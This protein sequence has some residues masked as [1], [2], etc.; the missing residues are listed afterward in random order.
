MRRAKPLLGTLVEVETDSGNSEQDNLAVNAAFAEIIRLE[1]LLTRF[2]PESDVARFNSLALDTELL[3]SPEVAVLFKLSQFLYKLTGGLFNPSV[4][5]ET[6]QAADFSKISLKGFRIKKSVP[7]EVDFAG[8]GKGYIV[9]LAVK[10]L[11]AMAPHSGLINAGGDIKV[12]GEKTYPVYIRSSNDA[13]K[14]FFSAELNNGAL[15]TSSGYFRG[16]TKAGKNF[17]P[18]FDPH[19]GTAVDAGLSVSV[20]ATS[21]WCAD[22]LTK[23]TA[24]LKDRSRDYISLLK[25]RAFL[26][27]G[28]FFREL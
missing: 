17:Q 22:A 25:A 24:L 7:L 28:D 11:R 4:N 3:L 26:Q 20:I 2:N 5:I 19:S 8:I 16:F 13:H 6:A 23:I 27:S 10:K 14:L 18:I 15:C 1:K 9:D 21:A 12:Y